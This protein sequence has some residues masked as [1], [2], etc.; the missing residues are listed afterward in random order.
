MAAVGAR[1]PRGCRPSRPRRCRRSTACA[2][3]GSSPRS[4][5]PSRK[6]AAMVLTLVEPSRSA[7]PTRSAPPR[8]L[9][10]VLE[11]AAELAA[12]RGDGARLQRA[13]RPGCRRSRDGQRV[14]GLDARRAL[15]RPAAAR[16]R[17][18]PAPRRAAPPGPRAVGAVGLDRLA[19]EAASAS[20][21]HS[22]MTVGPSGPSRSGGR[23][24]RW[25]ARR[26]CGLESW[27]ERL[28][29]AVGAEL[30]PGAVRGAALD[31]VLPALHRAVDDR[32]GL[33]G[34]RATPPSAARR[35]PAGSRCP[36]GT[37][38]TFQSCR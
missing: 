35:S 10:V 27:L 33:A 13:A 17:A 30:V 31:A 37:S 20:Q 34:R 15:A 21:K 3:P 28:V 5:S 9:V 8:R 4:R 1:C 7:A 38:I 23:P 6:P 32:G 26:R 18:A 36:S 11:R 19:H 12:Q 24:R 29:E 2:R 14:H 16:A 25:A 22:S